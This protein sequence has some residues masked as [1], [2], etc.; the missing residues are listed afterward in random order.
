[1]R[2]FGHLDLSTLLF[3]L[4][5]RQ[6]NLVG[7]C[8]A[9]DNINKNEI[10]K[11]KKLTSLSKLSAKNHQPRTCTAKN[12]H[13]SVIDKKPHRNAKKTIKT[14]FCKKSTLSLVRR[15]SAFRQQLISVAPTY[16][17]IGC[18]VSDH[19]H[20]T[21]LDAFDANGRLFAN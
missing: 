20:T 2:A 5:S 9:T 16:V 15:K 11:S 14:I 3:R 1:L 17:T 12:N 7:Y 19:P 8:R 10:V 4:R 21:I 18:Y 13:Q 6:L